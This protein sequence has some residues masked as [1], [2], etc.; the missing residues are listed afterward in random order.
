VD[1][2]K[3]RAAA[4]QLSIVSAW[5]FEEYGQN[6]SNACLVEAA[7]LVFQQPLQPVEPIG[8]NVLRYL[9]RCR[10]RW[11]TGPP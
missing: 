5:P 4:N 8:R 1:A 3:I 7:L 11:C 6:L 9:V 10:R 2:L